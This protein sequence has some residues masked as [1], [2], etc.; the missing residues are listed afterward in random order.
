MEALRA[1]HEQE[2]I[3]QALLIFVVPPS[4]D[5]LRERLV[6]RLVRTSPVFLGIERQ[7]VDAI[8]AFVRE[9]GV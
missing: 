5:V 2:S 3:P 1:L 7:L 9:P 4:F 6:A 8:A